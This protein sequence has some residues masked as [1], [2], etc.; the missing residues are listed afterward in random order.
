MASDPDEDGDHELFGSEMKIRENQS[1]CPMS[2]Q[3]GDIA[4]C[5]QACAGRG[6]AQLSVVIKMKIRLASCHCFV[7]PPREWRLVDE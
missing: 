5:F 6:I 2:Y 4:R 1:R 7:Y 3:T